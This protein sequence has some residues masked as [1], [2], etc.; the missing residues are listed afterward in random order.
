MLRR[1]HLSALTDKKEK[2]LT[3]PFGMMA[4]AGFISLGVRVLELD[5]DF[6][7]A[8]LKGTEIGF[9]V[10]TVILA[11]H[12]VDVVSLYFEKI[13]KD[14]ENKFDDIL[15]PLIKKTGKFFVIAVGVIAIGDALDLD[16]KVFLRVLELGFS[17][18]S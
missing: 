10:A 1:Y 9:T 6:L 8:I 11:H 16:M 5:K 18:F 12:L 7:L 15:V 3:F 4:L 13:A 17:F 2:Q 14:S